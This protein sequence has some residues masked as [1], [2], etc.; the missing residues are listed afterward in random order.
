MAKLFCHA[1]VTTGLVLTLLLSLL[2]D[3]VQAKEKIIKTDG[4][5]KFE[6]LQGNSYILTCPGG[7][8]LGHTG[9]METGAVY[10]L[11]KITCQKIFGDAMVEE[12][13]EESADDGRQGVMADPP[14]L[15]IF[16]E[17]QH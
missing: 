5:V 17:K 7:Q 12:E 10:Q 9:T 3:S 16:H 14:R 11:A 6:H 13:G 8:K 15:R 2:A 1:L 4:V